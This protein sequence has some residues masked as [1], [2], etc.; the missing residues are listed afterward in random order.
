LFNV[1]LSFIIATTQDGNSSKALADTI[2]K[3]LNWMYTIEFILQLVNLYAYY[4]VHNVSFISD[5]YKSNMI[6]GAITLVLLLFIIN[7]DRYSPS[8]P[9]TV[10]TVSFYGISNH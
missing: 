10:E 9:I 8:E 5:R 3:H 7:E 1:C 6:S 4:H 2:C